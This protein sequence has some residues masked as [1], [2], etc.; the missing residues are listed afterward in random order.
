MSDHDKIPVD[1]PLVQQLIAEQF[2]EWADLEI[3]PVVNGV[4]FIVLCLNVCEVAHIP[5]A[6]S[7]HSATSSPLKCIQ[8]PPKLKQD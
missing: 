5:P 6:S 4:G 2:P 8:K 1:V 7:Y 3:R